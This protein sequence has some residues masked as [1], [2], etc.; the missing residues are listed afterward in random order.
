MNKKISKYLSII[1]LLF[2]GFFINISGV[3]AEDYDSWV[4]PLPI[5]TSNQKLVNIV[6]ENSS[7]TEAYKLKITTLKNVNDTLRNLAE[8]KEVTDE[9]DDFANRLVVGIAN[10]DDSIE[11]YL[12]FKLLS[13]DLSSIKG[14][15]YVKL[16]YDSNKN[17]YKLEKS[18]ETQFKNQY[19]L[20]I[21]IRESD[22]AYQS[23][24]KE[25]ETHCHI[26]SAGFSSAAVDAM[27]RSFFYKN[28]SECFDLN[29]YLQTFGSIV[30]RLETNDVHYDKTKTGVLNKY[31]KALLEYANDTTTVGQ[32]SKKQLAE[33]WK[34]LQTIVDAPSIDPETLEYVDDNDTDRRGYGEEYY[35]GSITAI[36]K[37]IGDD[38]NIVLKNLEKNLDDNG[39]NDV[40]DVFKGTNR[41]PR[42]I[43]MNTFDRWF[44]YA[45][46]YLL[47]DST[48]GINKFINYYKYRYAIDLSLGSE[49]HKILLSL[50][51]SS[52]DFA[53]LIKSEE[54]LKNDPCLIYC[55]DCLS[56]EL[57]KNDDVTAANDS[58]IN[59]VKIQ[60]CNSC[61]NNDGTYKSCISAKIECNK[62]CASAQGNAKTECFNG[63]MEARLPGFT[64]KSD[65]TWDK[66]K[67][68]ET[69]TIKNMVT[70]SIELA[71]VQGL[72]IDFDEEGY[73]IQC[74][75]VSFLHTIYMV[76]I[77][78]APILVIVLGSIDY[79]RA[80]LESDE[81]KM[82]KFKK[83]FPKRL[84]MLVLLILV[85][86][87]VSFLTGNVAGLKDTLLNCVVNG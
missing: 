1:L 51:E 12:D 66:I 2:V 86:I 58:K 25:K 6:I 67:K 29:G 76:I 80:M 82:N 18:N 26:D 49:S 41:G 74:D 11:Y 46:R 27:F 69:D 50:L 24:W 79:F 60:N 39:K 45:G 17:E 55:P 53:K 59:D 8:E 54:D 63:C 68:A 30:F 48:A 84:I 14:T 85:P 3:K 73:E 61:R 10:S 13:L 37:Y 52:G 78:L 42:L 5:V 31:H 15:K 19:N 33:S 21:N 62:R 57:I 56:I 16:S 83:A 64:K 65:E 43:T 23:F 40:G 22:F 35:K 9:S 72:D 20:S 32:Y 87:I 70:K 36:E 34:I 28:S 7:P 44:Y 38:I 71:S 4:Y 77:I 75:D 47:E 81:Q